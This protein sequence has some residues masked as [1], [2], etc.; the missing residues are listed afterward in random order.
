VSRSKFAMA[1]MMTVM[2][3]LMRLLQTSAP[4][5]AL[6]RLACSASAEV[7]PVLDF[8]T[9]MGRSSSWQVGGPNGEPPYD[10]GYLPNLATRSFS[11]HTPTNAGSVD[12]TV[13]ANLSDP[14][15]EL[16]VI[17]EL[18]PVPTA[19]FQAA[20]AGL[21]RRVV[22][23]SRGSRWDWLATSAPRGP[24]NVRLMSLRADCDNSQLERVA[25]LQE[26]R[27]TFGWLRAKGD[28]Q[29]FSFTASASRHI[30]WL[31]RAEENVGSDIDFDLFVR[32]G[33][34]P[35]RNQHDALSVSSESGEAIELVTS[36]GQQIF[37]AVH[38][39]KGEGFI[40]CNNRRDD[41]ALSSPWCPA[42]GGLS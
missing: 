20:G 8:A 13:E 34:T 2:V 9:F 42:L 27:L 29:F 39:H 26:D 35:T 38:S 21:S 15:G 3:R 14:S 30:I 6:A 11:L 32:A 7:R 22:R 12:V 31:R 36:P 40:V 10:V 37:V 18:R 41:R 25:A 23:L 24:S 1:A 19:S 4:F 28:T 5:A 17:E 16:R 33:A